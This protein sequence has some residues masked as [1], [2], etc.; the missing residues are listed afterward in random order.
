MKR[1]VGYLFT[2]LITLSLSFGAS[3]ATYKGAGAWKSCDNQKG[4]YEVLADIQKDGDY[5]TISQ[6]LNFSDNRAMSFQVTLQRGNNDFF[7][8][9]NEDGEKIGKG[10]CWELDEPGHKFCHSSSEDEEGVVELSV[11]VT[12]KTIYRAGSKTQEGKPT[13]TSKDSLE[14][15]EEVAEPQA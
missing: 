10:Y 15:Q 7:A 8:V 5:V 6:T 3:A 4:T 1:S 13:I 12:P 9:L 2:A 14:L 11:G